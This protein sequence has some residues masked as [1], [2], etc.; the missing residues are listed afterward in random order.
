MNLY[1][2]NTDKGRQSVTE[3][4]RRGVAVTTDNANNSRAISRI[5]PGDGVLAYENG[6]GVIAFGEALPGNVREVTHQGSMVNGAERVEYH[7]PVR[8]LV[9]L[10][11]A[12]LTHTEVRRF[13]NVQPV[14]SSQQVHQGK[15]WIL[16]QVR[17]V[18]A[19]SQYE[20]QLE[21][22]T[23]QMQEDL[24]ALE[25]DQSRE[26]TTR[27]AL[28]E[29]RVGQGKFRADL[30]KEF[31]GRCAVSGLSLSPVLR[32]SHIVPWREAN[33]SQRLDPS[34][35]LLLRA[36]L[37]ALFD[38]AL[39]T[40][41][42]RGKLLVSMLISAEHRSAIALMGDLRAP[43]TEARAAYLGEHNVRFRRQEATAFFPR[44]GSFKQD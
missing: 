41:D 16:D 32:A 28:I 37:D 27:Q 29:A 6:V 44:E 43:P 18:A 38:F 2:V 36:D 24:A 15:Q 9:D 4:I 12:P 35:G 21:V 19:R 26:S 31:A 34:N 39:I 3:W 33:D 40:F 22:R 30:L 25:G 42:D 20:R 7:L 17:D 1:F 8:W 14:R 23:K 5:Q 13:A 10:R 11:E